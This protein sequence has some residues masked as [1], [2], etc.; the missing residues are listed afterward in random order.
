MIFKVRSLKALQKENLSIDWRKF[1]FIWKVL[2]S[3]KRLDE[4]MWLFLTKW[5]GIPI[6][7]FSPD[8]D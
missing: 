3:R 2:E 1:R 7:D 5:K 8:L 4:Y 6:T